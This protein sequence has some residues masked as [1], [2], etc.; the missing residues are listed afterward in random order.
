MKK[1]RKNSLAITIAFVLTCALQSCDYYLDSVVGSGNITTEY[2][3]LK[4]F[5]NIEAGGAFQV[6]LVEG[7]PYTLTIVADHNLMPFIST[8]VEG[9]TLKITGEARFVNTGPIKIYL[10]AER[11]DG[12]RLSGAATFEAEVIIHTS[13][14]DMRL[15]GAS[16]ANL[17]VDCQDIDLRISGASKA[18][19][20]L[21]A[22]EA[23]MRLSGA[24]NLMLV[25]NI[26][27]MEARLSGSAIINGFDA[28]VEDCK[29]RVSGA[30]KVNIKVISALNVRASGSGTVVYDGNPNDITVN[31]SGA[32]RVQKR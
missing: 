1:I 20:R 18:N 23:D 5:R 15:S 7:E 9:Q 28:W 8:Y 32:G 31:T 25:G 12:I 30:S 2:R 26:E 11:L 21:T 6:F 24:S 19:L 3:S 10:S 29:L 16:K 4:T 13:Q 27:E 14:M 17:E 22:N